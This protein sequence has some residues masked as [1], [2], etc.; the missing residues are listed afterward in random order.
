[1]VEMLPGKVGTIM[2]DALNKAGYKKFVAVCASCG[3]SPNHE[4]RKCSQCNVA[5][6]CDSECQKSH[7]KV[8]L[9]LSLFNLQ[10]LNSISLFL[11]IAL[12]VF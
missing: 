10:Y 6:Y 11:S 3:H 2:R 9:S 1:M 8:I 7:W 4:L 5:R 12:S